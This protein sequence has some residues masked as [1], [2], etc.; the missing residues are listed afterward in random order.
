MEVNIVGM[1]AGL[2]PG[3]SRESSP[4][5]ASYVPHALQCQIESV[6]AAQPRAGESR[7]LLKN[8]P[9]LRE[10]FVGR[11]R[12]CEVQKNP[13]WINA[14]TS[15]V[16]LRPAPSG[17]PTLLFLATRVTCRGLLGDLRKAPPARL[18]LVI[19]ARGK[20]L[21]YAPSAFAEPV[22]GFPAA[23]FCS[24]RSRADDS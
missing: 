2:L 16:F 24:D 14:D 15:A 9:L 12:R 22:A 11:P 20:V 3:N 6:T 10:T 7:R 21:G 18:L 17:W 19:S 5:R 1:V 8:P 13:Q 4:L 23:H